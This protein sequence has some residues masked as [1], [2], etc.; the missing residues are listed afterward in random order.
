MVVGGELVINGGF[1][2]PFGEDGWTC[3]GCQM[4]RT[5]DAYSGAYSARVYNR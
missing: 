5:I 2:G 3:A 1:E 4:E